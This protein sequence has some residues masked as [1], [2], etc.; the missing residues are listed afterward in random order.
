MTLDLYLL[1]PIKNFYAENPNVEIPWC[2]HSFEFPFKG[3]K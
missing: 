3:V 1:S 2:S